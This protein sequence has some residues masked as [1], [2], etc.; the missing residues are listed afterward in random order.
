[1]SQNTHQ[2]SSQK[3]PIL[4]MFVAR[5][6]PLLKKQQNKTTL[7]IQNK[8]KTTLNKTKYNKT[9]QNKSKLLRSYHGLIVLSPDHS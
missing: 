4:A 8:N 3:T 5:C 9:E 6:L 7:N 2:K 1:V